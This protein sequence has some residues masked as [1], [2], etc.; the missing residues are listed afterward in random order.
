MW[1]QTLFAEEEAMKEVEEMTA[2]EKQELIEMLEKNAEDYDEKVV[3]VWKRFTK[4][5]LRHHKHACCGFCQAVVNGPDELYVMP[6]KFMY[7]DG[8]CLTLKDAKYLRTLFRSGAKVAVLEQA[9]APFL[10]PPALALFAILQRGRTRPYLYIISRLYASVAH[11]PTAVYVADHALQAVYRFGGKAGPGQSAP[12]GGD[13]L[14]MI[15]GACAFTRQD[16]GAEDGNYWGE[17]SPPNLFEYSTLKGFPMKRLDQAI[18]QAVEERGQDGIALIHG[19]YQPRRHS[20]KH[21]DSDTLRLSECLQFGI[22][23]IMDP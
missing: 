13:E 5:N 7:R 12:A 6:L 16:Y 23:G 22:P 3:P 17:D 8:L 18:L 11:P 9:S 14:I 10:S 19:H 2:E 15:C 4:A 1:F 20:F 21:L